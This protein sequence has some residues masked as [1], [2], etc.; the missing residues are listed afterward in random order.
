MAYYCKRCQREV[1]EEEVFV[2]EGGTKRHKTSLGSC[3][4]LI[5]GI[6]GRRI[7]PKKSR[8]EKLLEKANV[9]A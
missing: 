6:G 5:T 7:E 2:T 1:P 4:G 3:R 9:K 8:I